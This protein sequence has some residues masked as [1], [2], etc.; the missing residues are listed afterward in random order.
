MEIGDLGEE[1]MNRRKFLSYLLSGPA[2]CA[3]TVSTSKAT[4]EKKKLNGNFASFSSFD[5]KQEKRFI[6]RL[7]NTTWDY[8]SNNLDPLGFIDHRPIYDYMWDIDN[9]TSLISANLVSGRIDYWLPTSV[10]TC[11]VSCVHKHLYKNI[12]SITLTA[13]TGSP[14]AVM[15][16]NGDGTYIF[17]KC[18]RQKKD[19]WEHTWIFDSSGILIGENNG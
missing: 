3:F 5:A 6:W 4:D 13:P 16:R 14:L 10:K 12:F 11:G 8:G 19:M 18:T 2:A 9:S 1:K 15:T 17:Q 7:L